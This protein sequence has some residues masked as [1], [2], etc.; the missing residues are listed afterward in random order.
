MG[1]R[2]SMDLDDFGGG[3]PLG[4]VEKGN[5]IRIYYMRKSVFSSK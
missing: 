5:I 4:E 1:V 3:E 2:K